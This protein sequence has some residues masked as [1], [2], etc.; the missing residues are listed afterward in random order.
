[1]IRAIVIRGDFDDA[2]FNELV[3]LIRTIDSR[4]PDRSYLIQ[5]SDPIRTTE[6]CA[7]VVRA[8]LPPRD[9]RETD[10]PTIVYPHRGKVH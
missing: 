2:D 8:A 10:A 9:D 5:C 6:Q 3:A 1:M 4:H 7:E